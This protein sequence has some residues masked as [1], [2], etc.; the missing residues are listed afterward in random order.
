MFNRKIQ[1]NSSYCYFIL[2]NHFPLN[3]CAVM[4]N[5]EAMAGCDYKAEGYIY[6]TWLA[7][8]L[9]NSQED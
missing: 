5:V 8:R 1:I 7:S 9:I 3:Q 2:F 4:L 6:F